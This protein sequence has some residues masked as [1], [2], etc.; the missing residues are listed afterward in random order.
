VNKT[1]VIS[2]PEVDSAA[3]ADALVAR[4]VMW[5]PSCGAGCPRAVVDQGL[6]T[7]SYSLD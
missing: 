4:F 5:G 6:L 2:L 1:D 7:L 3:K